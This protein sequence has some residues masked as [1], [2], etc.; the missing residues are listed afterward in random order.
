MG[1]LLDDLY[2]RELDNIPKHLDAF[3]QIYDVVSGDKKWRESDD[4]SDD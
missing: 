3:N 1:C 4:E 2:Q